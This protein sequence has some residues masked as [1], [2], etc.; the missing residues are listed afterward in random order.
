MPSSGGQTLNRSTFLGNQL[1][2]LA[3]S[4]PKTHFPASSIAHPYCAWLAHGH[5]QNG[6]FVI[7]PRKSRQIVF[8]SRERVPGP[9]NFSRIESINNLFIQKIS[10][11]FD[12]WKKGITENMNFDSTRQRKLWPR[13][14][15]LRTWNISESLSIKYA[16]FYYETSIKLL[17][18]IDA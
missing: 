11:N 14:R 17:F 5:E 2:L 4:V 10:T 7:G 3:M 1:V 9:I 13:S 16:W 12:C 6:G 8:F 18:P 15:T